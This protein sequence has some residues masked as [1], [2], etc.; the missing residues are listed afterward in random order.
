MLMYYG[1]M[2]SQE[3]VKQSALNPP[4][5]ILGLQDRMVTRVTVMF[6]AG[7]S[8]K[9]PALVHGGKKQAERGNPKRAMSCHFQCVVC[10]YEHAV[11]SHVALT[12]ALTA[13]STGTVCR[14]GHIGSTYLTDDTQ[15]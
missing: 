14:G 7:I 2:G 13:Y 9:F 1:L 12:A 8:P 11:A 3:S 6:T 10:V 5:C 15:A 4:C